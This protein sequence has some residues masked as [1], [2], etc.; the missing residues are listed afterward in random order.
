MTFHPLTFSFTSKSH[1]AAD[2]GFNTG[3]R[4]KMFPEAGQLSILLAEE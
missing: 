1:W 4:I 2:F 3:Q